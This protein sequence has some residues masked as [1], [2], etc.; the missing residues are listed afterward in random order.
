MIV[1]CWQQL[2]IYAAR[3]IGAFVR[4]S[5]EEVVVLRTV[6]DRFP[7]KGAAE[8]TGTKVID[9]SP[10]DVRRIMDIVGC[11]PEIIVSGGWGDHGFW[12]WVKE[13]K[14]AGGYSIVCTDEPYRGKSWREILRKIRFKMFLAR[15]IDFMFVAG[16]GGIKQFVEY[17]GLSKSRVVEGLYAGDR[18]LFYNGKPIVQRPK[19]FIY[20][21]HYDANKNVTAMCRA[22]GRVQKNGW[23][24]EVYGGGPLEQELKRFENEFIHIHGYV[25]ADQLGP[26]Y[27]DARC[28]VLGSHAEQW[29]VVVH[30]ACMSGCMLLLSNHVGSRF[31]FAMPENSV[32]FNPDSEDD[33][34]RGFD[35]VMNKTDDECL[36]AQQKSLELGLR[37][38]PDKFAVNLMQMIASVRGVHGCLS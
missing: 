34:A 29:G 2:P 38:S 10:N 7:I 21:G 33:F 9:V 26:M 18:Q 4:M 22:F 28:F 15:H 27:R 23:S 24:L 17:Y 11:T 8:M 5:D 19:K 20:V 36:S 14:G 13:I 16:A 31:D 3:N 32:M 6:T 35:E 12:R 30:E 25:N 37:F 1:F